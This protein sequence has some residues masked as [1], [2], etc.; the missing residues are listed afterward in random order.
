MLS[1]TSADFICM[2]ILS[3]R[4]AEACVVC[5]LGNFCGNSHSYYSG[6]LAVY[7]KFGIPI[8]KN[9]YVNGK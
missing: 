4:V 3:D 1:L 2:I 9:K 6:D 7:K 8:H 5:N